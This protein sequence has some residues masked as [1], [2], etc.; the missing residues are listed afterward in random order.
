MRCFPWTT[1][2]IIKNLLPKAYIEHEYFGKMIKEFDPD[3]FE[4][5]TVYISFNYKE[6]PSY[7]SD[8]IAVLT[9]GDEKGIPPEYKDKIACTFKHHLD[10]DRISNV[11]HIPLPYVS[12][13]NGT[14][15]VPINDRQYDVFFV[16]RNSK[17][18]DMFQALTQLQKKR[19]NLKFCVLDT[20]HRFKGGWPIEKYAAAMSNSKIVLS[21]RGAVRAECIRFTEAVMCNCA[22]IA[23]KHPD[24]TCFNSC[25]AE[26]IDT[27]DC[28][29]ATVDKLLSDKDRLQ[30]ISNQMQVSWEQHFSPEAEGRYI[31]QIVSRY[32]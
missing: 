31:N 12:G 17:R 29:E 4:G 2:M 23:C 25:P 3:I 19:R 13:F 30:K 16:G 11:Y 21:P 24:V 9:A 1:A 5:K 15:H 18:A 8:I 6:L 7:G 22:I 28:L 27:W 10:A 14:N 20:G 26:Y 32:N